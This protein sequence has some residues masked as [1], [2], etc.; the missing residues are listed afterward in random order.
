MNTQNKQLE[1]NILYRTINVLYFC[2]WIAGLLFISVLA[3]SFKPYEIVDSQNSY[4]NCNNGKKYTLENAKIYLFVGDKY[5][6]QYNDTKARKVCEYGIVDDYPN[7]YKTPI[8]A[9]YTVDTVHKMS[10]AWKDVILTIVIGCLVLFFGLN[11][12]KETLLYLFFG[13]PFSLG[14]LIKFISLFKG[15]NDST[16]SIKTHGKIVEDYGKVITKIAQE[17]YKYPSSIYPIHLLPYNKATIRES[18]EV[19]Y[20]L[21]KNNGDGE[22]LEALK[23]AYALLDNFVYIA[24]S[25]DKSI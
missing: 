24:K 19:V 13:R 14:W 3:Y 16:T 6:G 11:L 4:I 9:N 2:T 21:N 22:Q 8:Y 1:Q 20:E 23:T 10:G 15:N 7:N 18:L 5:M 25:D 17:K 12:I